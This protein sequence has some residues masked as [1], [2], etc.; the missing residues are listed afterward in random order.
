MKCP[1]KMHGI[2]LTVY[3]RYGEPSIKEDSIILIAAVQTVAISSLATWR[4]LS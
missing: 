2:I 3:L 1:K 4:R